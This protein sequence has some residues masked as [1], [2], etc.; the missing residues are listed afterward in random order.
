[1]SGNGSEPGPLIFKAVRILKASPNLSVPQAMRAAGMTMSDSKL[2]RLQMQVRR[3]MPAASRVSTSPPP[4]SIH[5]GS[6]NTAI[7]RRII[8]FDVS[9]R[10]FRAEDKI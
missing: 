7:R 2:A 1:M 9:A 8:A 3:R 6:P 5:A 10:I 4:S